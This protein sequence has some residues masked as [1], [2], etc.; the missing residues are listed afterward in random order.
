MSS[1]LIVATAAVATI[2]GGAAALVWRTG[3]ITE[4]HQ[5]PSLETTPL[6]AC[7][8]SGSGENGKDASFGSTA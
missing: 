4:G 3:P 1:S 2:A 8:P 7:H 5:V 6:P